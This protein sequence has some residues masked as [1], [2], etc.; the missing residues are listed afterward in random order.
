MLRI[1]IYKYFSQI[2][3]APSWPI[4]PKYRQKWL[5]FKEKWF[6]LIG[7]IFLTEKDILNLFRYLKSAWIQLSP[8]FQQISPI[9]IA[10]PRKFSS[11]LNNFRKKTFLLRIFITVIAYWLHFKGIY[12]LNYFKNNVRQQRFFVWGVGREEGGLDAGNQNFDRMVSGDGP[13]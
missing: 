12:H 2:S 3:T 4:K 8:R 1:C 13:K 10:S 7:H 9:S 5:K 11:K 6:F